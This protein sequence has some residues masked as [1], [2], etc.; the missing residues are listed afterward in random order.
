MTTDTI[1]HPPPVVSGHWR[2][3]TNILI[4]FVFGCV[5][6]AF[7]MMLIDQH[8][9]GDAL[10]R[11]ETSIGDL[12][13]RRLMRDILLEPGQRK[14]VH[15]L[16]EA[17]AHQRQELEVRIRPQIQTLDQAT[18]ARIDALLQPD[19]REQFHNNLAQI[20]EHYGHKLFDPGAAATNGASGVAPEI[21]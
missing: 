18:T 17:N 10:L 13:E 19:Q 12:L 4:I 15:D 1:L 6:G 14:S 5:S 9:V 21:P 3:V 20:E 2:T 8:R 16:F 7:S 11:G